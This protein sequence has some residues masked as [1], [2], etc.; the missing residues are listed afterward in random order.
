MRCSRG[1]A[2]VFERAVAST[3]GI[4]RRSPCRSME[5]Y[6]LAAEY[7]ALSRCCARTSVTKRLLQ[8]CTRIYT[9][10]GAGIVLLFTLSP[11]PS[12]ST[13]DGGSGSGS[14]GAAARGL[15]QL[16]RGCHHGHARAAQGEGARR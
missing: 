7:E 13:R 15:K 6:G 5:R 11:L 4:A 1:S 2:P 14:N 3:V 12:P 10:H 9:T 8:S 16:K